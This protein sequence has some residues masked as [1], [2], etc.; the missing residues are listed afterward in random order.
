MGETERKGK[1][2]RREQRKVATTTQKKRERRKLTVSED[3]IQKR[4]VN[5]RIR[6]LQ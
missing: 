2:V 1:R 4:N 6:N 3:K 5:S